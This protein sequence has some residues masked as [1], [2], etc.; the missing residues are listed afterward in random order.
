VSGVEELIVPRDVTVADLGQGCD[1]SK[2]WMLPN[3]VPRFS[4]GAAKKSFCEAGESAGR[5]LQRL[6]RS[7]FQ[8]QFAEVAR[9]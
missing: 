3:V 2:L 4:L 1:R 6:R 8:S 9:R 7:L 5:D